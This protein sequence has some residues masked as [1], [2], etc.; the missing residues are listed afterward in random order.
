VRGAERARLT[1]T[2]L[3]LVRLGAEAGVEDGSLAKAADTIAEPALRARA[4]LLIL[5][6]RLARSKD[7]VGDDALAAI[8]GK[9]ASHYR[10]REELARHN[11]QTNSGYA[12]TVQGWDERYRPF[13]VIG[14]LLK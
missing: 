13:G 14:T 7:A 4:H 3:H 10:A 8:D 5:R 9:T 1:W 2:L 12:K 6:G 11:V